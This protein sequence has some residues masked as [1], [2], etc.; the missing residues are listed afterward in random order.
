MYVKAGEETALIKLNSGVTPSYFRHRLTDCFQ[1]YVEVVFM[2]SSEDLAS[3]ARS[4]SLTKYEHIIVS[5]SRTQVPDVF[6][7]GCKDFFF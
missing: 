6:Y 2:C 1:I 3:R 7:S 5:Q 4:S